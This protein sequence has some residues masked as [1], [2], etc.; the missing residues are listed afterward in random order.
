MSTD[1]PV[2][3]LRIAQVAPLWTRVPPVTYGGTELRVHWLT[4]GL[5]NGGHDVTLYAS[6]DSRTH[7]RLRSVFG[8][9]VLDAMLQG[10]AHSYEHYANALFAEALEDGESF[11]VIHVHGDVSQMPFAVLS[12]VPVLCSLRT[13]LSIDDYW[14]MERYATVT[15][16]AMSRSQVKDAPGHGRQAI[17]VIYNGCDFGAYDVIGSPG[18]YLAFLGRMGP[19]KNPR[20]A[21][22]IAQR[23]GLPIVLAGT[24]Q[25]DGERQ[26]VEDVI[27]PLID[28]STVKYIGPVGQRQKREFLSR[29]AA[30]IF[31]ILWEEPFG[32]V[33]IEAMASGTPVVAYT[34]GSVPE[35]V[36]AGMTGFYGETV[37]DLVEMIPQALALDRRAVREHAERRFS[38][39][40]MVADYLRLYR[41]LLRPEGNPGGTWM[42]RGQP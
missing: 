35:V 18:E 14:L 22:R 25:D 17:P 21:I 41:S 26:Y 6:G 13:A 4:E 12:P 34:R 31:P 33:M 10:E 38:H 24:A 1:T 29:A 7:A 36:D 28:G 30:L 23:A 5:V 27:R 8:R 42:N 19:H 20:D 11:D 32:N 9:S 39:E 15:F 2:R 40:R 3:P 37:D 16:A